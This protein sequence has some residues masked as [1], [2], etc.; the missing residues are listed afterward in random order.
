MELCSITPWAGIA[1]RMS[2]I[3]IYAHG[4]PKFCTPLAIISVI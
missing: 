1:S 2:I 4:M 3:D